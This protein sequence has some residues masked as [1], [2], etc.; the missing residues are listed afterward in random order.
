MDLGTV[1]GP[2]ARFV[3]VGGLG[4]GARLGYA[5][6]RVLEAIGRNPEDTGEVRLTSIFGIAMVEV[7]TIYALLIALAIIFAS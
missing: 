5:V 1:V 4:P 6:E 7:I 2:T 3:G